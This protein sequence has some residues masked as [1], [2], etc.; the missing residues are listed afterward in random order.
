MNEEVWV[1]VIAINMY[2]ESLIS[3][4]GND[5]L[6]KLVP[7]A[8]INL[9][10]DHLITDHTQ[11][12]LYWEEGPINGGLTVE[13]YT[14]YYDNG[15][16]DGVFVELESGVP[17]SFYTTTAALTNNVYYTFK[18]T[19]RND[20]GSSLLS[21]QITILCAKKPDPPVNLADVPSITTAYQIGLQWEDGPFD[22]GSPIIDYRLSYKINPMNDTSSDWSVY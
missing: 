9:F 19:A 5:G 1:K 14:I 21:P 3:D 20:V 2:G 17:T 11:I 10:N 7:D 12:K 4:K 16:G 13:D 8:P 15:T 18:V 22:G 6:V